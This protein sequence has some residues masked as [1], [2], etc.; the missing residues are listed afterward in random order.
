MAFKKIYKL[1]FYK[2]LD[3]LPKRDIWHPAGIPKGLPK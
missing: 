1:L 3:T 2:D